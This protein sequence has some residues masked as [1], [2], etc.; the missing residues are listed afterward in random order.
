MS[1]EQTNYIILIAQRCLCKNKHERLRENKNNTEKQTEN[2][3]ASWKK[4]EVGI[5]KVNHAAVE[6]SSTISK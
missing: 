3:D 6:T 1:R 4:F 2:S 5:E